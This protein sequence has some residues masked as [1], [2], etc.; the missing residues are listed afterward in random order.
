M[1]D[2]TF[3]AARNYKRLC[4]KEDRDLLNTELNEMQDLAA[5]D[6]TVILDRILAAGTI[7]SGLDASAQDSNVTIEDGLVY[8]D[9]CAVGVSGA[10]LSCADPGEHIIYVDVFRRDVT[11][12]EDPTLVN[13]LTGEAT[14][15]REKWIATLQFRDTS[16]D[17]LPQGAKSRSVAPVY[18]FNRDTGEI[19]P[20]A[21]VAGDGGSLF[22][23]LA[24]ELAAHKA[25]DDHD[26]RYHTKALADGR[27]A[28]IG[29][30]GAAGTSQHPAATGSAAG[31]MSASDKTQLGN[32]ET[33]VTSVEN[34]LPNKAN[35][36]DVTAVSNA[37]NT[38]KAS[39]DHDSRYYTKSQTDTA[40]AAKADVTDLTAAS[41]ALETHKASADHD[42]RYY[43]KALSDGRFAPIGHVGSGGTAQHPA[44][45]GSTAGFMGSGDK[46]NLD[47]LSAEITA[48]RTSDSRGAFASL[49]ARMENAEAMAMASAT[50]VVAAVDSVRKSSAHYVCDGTADQVE[51]NQ[52]LNALPASGGK[53]LLLAGTYTLA[54]GIEM[55]LGATLAGEGQGTIIKLRS[56]HNTNISL[57]KNKD[58][59]AHMTCVRDL[60][61]D[62]NKDGQSSGTVIGVEWAGESI[63][64]L[65][66][67]HRIHNVGI[68]NTSL[69]MSVRFTHSCS[70]FQNMLSGSGGILITRISTNVSVVGNTIN[71]VALGPG[72]GILIQ[73]EDSTL[74]KINGALVADNQMQNCWRGVH[75]GEGTQMCVVE[76]NV[77][78]SCQIGIS[79]AS[80]SAETLRIA[81]DH[82]I[83]GNSIIAPQTTSIE[84]T[85]VGVY[86]ASV[87][88]NQL[89][90][91]MQG[92]G[93]SGRGAIELD[94]ADMTMIQSNTIRKSAGGADY[95]ILIKSGTTKTWVSNNDLRLAGVLS[96]ISDAGTETVTAAGNQI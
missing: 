28:P 6:R 74:V 30:V 50:Y 9:G 45:T 60:R 24:A 42:A 69:G 61:V 71:Y 25:S 64:N 44:A 56:A 33:R 79:I 26:G 94:D 51:I 77:I 78:S 20:A 7:L 8:I 31:F 55:P 21:G 43:T 53:V 49:D 96:G 39:S 89:V 22:P 40:L 34:T 93:G 23:E 29:H 65:T 11:A 76:S 19:R 35:N 47:N 5:H 82:L 63:D 87:V 57:I 10:T 85:G 66:A 37:L 72:D 95:G 4:Y 38:H 46:T 3:D 83:S 86:S 84:L 16:G 73:S 15:E 12:S 62:G 80:A 68:T 17:P 92:G 27:F 54:G 41:A 67:Y 91:S 18:I 13:Q 14:A 1:S 52:A 59:A 58:F 32:H 90:G 75:I 88:G 81:T 2:S 48:A 36:S 70:I